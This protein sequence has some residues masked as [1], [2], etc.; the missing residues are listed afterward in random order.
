MIRTS[1]TN[2]LMVL[3]QFFEYDQKKIDGPPFSISEK[4]VLE[5][6]KEN[7]HIS[8]RHSEERESLSPR[9]LEKGIK[10]IIQKVYLLKKL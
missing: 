4:E 1:T 10:D 2:E 8:M 5:S 9:F 3:V 7:F 6:L